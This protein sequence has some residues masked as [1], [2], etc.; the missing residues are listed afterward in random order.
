[1]WSLG[2]FVESQLFGIHAMDWPT[3]VGAAALVALV[4]VGATGL[5]M[6]RATSISPMDALRCE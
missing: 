3:V 4:A 1:V 2:R 5:P 6:R